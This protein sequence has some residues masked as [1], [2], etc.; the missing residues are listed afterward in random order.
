MRLVALLVLVFGVALAGGAIFFASEAFRAREAALLRRNTGPET[1]GVLVAGET[2]E[3]GEA[4]VESSV[5]IVQWPRNAVPDGAFTDAQA[6][7]GTD[8]DEPRYVLRSIGKGEPIISA[9]LSDFGERPRVVSTLPSG[10][11]AMSIRIDA[12]SGVAGFV[13]PGDRVDIVLTRSVG[14]ELTSSIVLQDI[15]II[16]VD[17]KSDTEAASPRLGRVAT[18]AVTT[19]D[20]LRLTAAQNA[21]K[22]SLVLRGSEEVGT[23]DIGPIRASDL[24]GEAPVVE[25]TPVPSNDTAVRVRR[26]ADDP[27]T[28]IFREGGGTETIRG[29][30]PA[31]GE[32]E[33]PTAG[34]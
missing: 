7:I 28:E 24:S 21:G 9:K 15:Q 27:S 23:T 6:L 2:L 5:R 13:A 26:G 8:P 25:P 18:V 1:V 14:R 32:G 16:A 34:Q 30:A 33:T 22:L 31:A 17:Q 11:R 12:V 20:S 19:E 10:M 3:Y 29:G 4:L